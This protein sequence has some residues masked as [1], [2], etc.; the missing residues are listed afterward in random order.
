MSFI[1]IK[2]SYYRCTGMI[3]YSLT[4]SL[5]KENCNI[6]VVSLDKNSI[7]LKVKNTKTMIY[8]ILIIV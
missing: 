2:N 3:G 4:K 5:I 1:K 7:N 6:T 8:E